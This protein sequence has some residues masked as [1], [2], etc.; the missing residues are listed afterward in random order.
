MVLIS[1]LCPVRPPTIAF[2]LSL[3]I[4]GLSVAISGLLVA[5]KKMGP[6][7]DFRPF[8]ISGNIHSAWKNSSPADLHYSHLA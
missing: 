7:H 1:V 3:I 2:R 4:G 5:S 6:C 8:A